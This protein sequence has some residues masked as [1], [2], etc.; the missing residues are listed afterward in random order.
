MNA[1]A[2]ASALLLACVATLPAAEPPKP[3]DALRLPDGRVL[4]KAVL[5]EFKAEHVLVRHAGGAAVVRYEFLPDAVRGTAE[6][7]RPGGPR[8]F[9]GD[10]SADTLK[11]SGQ[12]YVQTRGS[13]PYKFGATPVYVFDLNY[14]EFWKQPGVVRLPKAIYETV[15]DADGKFTIS[16]P[17]DRPFFIFAQATRLVSSDHTE[18]LEWRVPGDS[19][20]FPDN[21]ALNNDNVSAFRTV[22]IEETK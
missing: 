4:K 6:Q 7:K 13:G 9:P 16:V 15:T 10:T 2:A 5:A 3:I 19:F 20:K 14:L 1:K 12:V 11:Y 8:W 18:Q 21:A 22:V 17:A